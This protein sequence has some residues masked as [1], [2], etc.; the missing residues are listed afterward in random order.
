M[1]VIIPSIIPTSAA[2][3]AA[4]NSNS[5]PGEGYALAGKLGNKPGP[6]ATV[7]ISSGARQAAAAGKGHA[8]KHGLRPLNI[9]WG[10]SPQQSR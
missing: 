7:E 10:D 4:R 1:S 6:A 2:A 3:N 5:A 8:P 9:I